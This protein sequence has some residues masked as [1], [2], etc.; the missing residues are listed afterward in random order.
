MRL[1][2]SPPA[3]RTP[4]QPTEYTLLS[5]TPELLPTMTTPCWPWAETVQFSTRTFETLSARTP[6]PRA[7][8]IV[9]PLSVT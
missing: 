4:E 5:V 7:C 6:L 2:A 3:T 8:L 9:R 1:W